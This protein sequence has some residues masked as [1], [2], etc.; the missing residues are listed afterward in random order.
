[1]TLGLTDMPFSIPLTLIHSD[2]PLDSLADGPVGSLVT[3]DFGCALG[4][5]GL[6]VEGTPGPGGTG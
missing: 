2:K 6:L 1:M 4:L 3:K 5:R